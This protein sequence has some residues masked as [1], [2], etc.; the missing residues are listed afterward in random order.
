MAT[1]RAV[2]GAGPD[3]LSKVKLVVVSDYPGG[4]EAEVGYPFWSNDTSPRKINRGQL[5]GKYT[6]PSYPTAG[7][8]IRET[9]YRLFGLDT[10]EE[11]WCTNAIKCTKF[12][13]EG[14][15]RTIASK[16][17]R[18]CVRTHL[19]TEL[20]EIHKH[21]PDCPILIAGQEAFR[22]IYFL[23]SKL[24]QELDRLKLRRARRTNHFRLWGHPLVFTFNPA[25][26]K[27]NEFRI[28]SQQGYDLGFATIR[29]RASGFDV[30]K[31]TRVERLP[32]SFEYFVGSPRW[33]YEQ[34]LAFLRPFL[35][36]ILQQN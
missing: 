35:Q 25:T 18:K 8:Y 20:S 17:R 14:E 30:N 32:S 19:L 28:E 27:D 4:Y 3:D 12:G 29:D 16:H 21:N 26:V 33:I 15:D 22:A 34:D 24:F 6:T 13:P 1:G 10:Y 2:G 23:D 5:K 9:L 7:R 36:Q 11:V 31:I